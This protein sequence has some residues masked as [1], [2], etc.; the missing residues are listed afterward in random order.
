MDKN[1]YASIHYWLRRNFVNEQVCENKK[2]DGTS[3]VFD[4]ALKK[5][6]KHQ[7]KR[8]NYFRYCRKCHTKYDMTEEK[9]IRLIDISHTESANDKRAKSITGLKKPK[10]SETAK[11]NFSFP[12]LQI[13][14]GKIVNEFPSM[15]EAARQTGVNLTTIYLILKGKVKT[16]KKYDWKFKEQHRRRKRE[17]TPKVFVYSSGV[18]K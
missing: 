10:A 4:W 18:K 13:Y 14:Q 2:C 15:S 3:K 16:F 6:K 9:R 8:S 1:E 5:G 12:V 11:K 7:R 17:A